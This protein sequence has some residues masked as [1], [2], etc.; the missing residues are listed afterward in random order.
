MSCTRS[1]ART[2]SRRTRP[3]GSGRTRSRVALIGAEAV[4]KLHPE[5]EPQ[6]RVFDGL[7]RF[8]EL[9]T[10]AMPEAGNPAADALAV[11][12]QLK[13][14]L[15][16]GYLPHLTLVRVVRPRGA[17]GRLLAAAGGAV[18]E[19]CSGDA[20]G[21]RLRPG[22]L[23]TIEAPD[24]AAAAA[25][26]ARAGGGRRRRARGRGDV[27]PPR[28]LPHAH[29]ARLTGPGGRAGLIACGPR[30]RTP[31][32]ACWRRSRPTGR[33]RAAPS[34]SRTTPRSARAPPTRPRSCAC[35][36]RARGAPPTWSRRSGPTTAATAR[37]RS[38]SSSST[39]TR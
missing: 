8:L 12:F 22:S 23:E 36:G 28:R 4:L 37:T 29:P 11:G 24:R 2:S 21:F 33:S 32:R 3:C 17:A 19:H 15:L 20:D 16:A 26:P 1:R 31:S 25:R 18:C 6:P 27:R 7:V 9:L 10:G 39:S 34:C 14:L 30:W 35:S 5:P 13:L 38:G